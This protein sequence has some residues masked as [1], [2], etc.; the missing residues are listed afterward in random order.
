MKSATY[1]ILVSSLV[2]LSVGAIAAPS[3]AKQWTACDNEGTGTTL[4]ANGTQLQLRK[5]NS[6]NSSLGYS[7]NIAFNSNGNP[8]NA[9][10]DASGNSWVVSSPHNGNAVLISSSSQ[11]INLEGSAGAVSFSNPSEHKVLIY[12]SIP[13]SPQWKLFDTVTG[14]LINNLPA[15]NA[16][17]NSTE[18]M[19]VAL[20]LSWKGD[21]IYT[22]PAGIDLSDGVGSI[23]L[24]DPMSA[25]EIKSLG[26]KNLSIVNSVAMDKT[27]VILATRNGLVSFVDKKPAWGVPK[28][29][30]GGF[31][32]SLELSSSAKYLLAQSANHMYGAI[33]DSKTGNVLASWSAGK[34]SG[35]D[36]QQFQS[37]FSGNGKR[38]SPV[39]VS[40]LGDELQFRSS[41]RP[42]S[43]GLLD[44]DKKSFVKI[45]IS[46]AD[47]GICGTGT[48]GYHEIP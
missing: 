38:H 6:N 41:A 8:I 40:F 10:A 31:F 22:K 45:H 44:V 23:K 24:L 11:P 16:S 1:F 9:I 19:P 47:A 3:A 28:F 37:F 17:I 35:I 18:S 21:V 12:A 48:Q 42:N 20:G 33:V 26:F 13:N 15:A 34:T 36:D 14:K 7:G 30:D 29:P 43:V 25:K 32:S 27:T 5:Q 39:V 46:K 2:S 4:T